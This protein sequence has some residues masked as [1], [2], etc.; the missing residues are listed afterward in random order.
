MKM[1][2]FY[3]GDGSSFFPVVGGKNLSVQNM[4]RIALIEA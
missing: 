1:K 2:I 4:C 3:P